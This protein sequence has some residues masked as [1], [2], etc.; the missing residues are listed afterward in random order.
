MKILDSFAWFEYFAGSKAG[1]RVRAI[2]ESGETTGTP[3]SGIA[4]IKR[5]RKR[6]GKSYDRELHFISSRSEIIPLT[7]KI[8]LRAG[9]IDTLH[10]ADALAYATALEHGATLVT[11]DPHFKG[12]PN[13]ELLGHR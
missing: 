13:I 10:F 8:A 6:E 5:K 1:E 3:A 9:D 12:L 2:L 11:G 4:E 7:L